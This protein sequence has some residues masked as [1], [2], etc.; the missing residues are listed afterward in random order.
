[1]KRFVKTAVLPSAAL[2]ALVLSTTA[3]DV[4]FQGMNAQAT[5][6]WKRTYKLSDG[7]QFHLSNPNGAIEVTPSVDATTVEV[8]AA[9]RARA[10]SE[11]A[12]K[13]EL[14]N[15]QITDQVTPTSI[16]I[17][18]ARRSD[19]GLHMGRG[20]R[21]VSFK[22]KVP[23]NAA[24]TLETRNGEVHVTGLSGSVKVDSSNGP[25]V[26]E[27]LSG[28]VLAGTTNGAV[29]IQVAALHPEGIRLDTTNGA[30]DLKIPADAR[31]NISARWVNGGFRTSGID[32]EGQRERRRFEGKL[33]GGG[34]RIELSTTN[35]GIHISG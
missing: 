23:R 34:P 20:G 33:N 16:R 14:K 30:I 32:P 15:I 4:V 12:A 24:V 18:V 2:F 10:S 11:A 35:G 31:A 26:G 22:I 17:E 3:C 25:I 28:P 1:M 13:E 29:R 5:D 19:S 7:G 21:E 27:D 9:R 8:V 6:E